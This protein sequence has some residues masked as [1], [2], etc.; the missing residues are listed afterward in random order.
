MSLMAAREFRAHL[1]SGADAI[2]EDGRGGP[3]ASELSGIRDS[4]RKDQETA[5]FLHG[6]L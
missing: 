2:D 3:F 6:A 5:G 4:D 1:N